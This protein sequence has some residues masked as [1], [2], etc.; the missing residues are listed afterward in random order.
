VQLE[1]QQVPSMQSPD[2][3]VA[4]VT[5]A[6]PRGAS[7]VHTLPTHVEPGAQAALVVHD[8]GHAAEPVHV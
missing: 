5:Q 4:A 2:A 6:V 1:L 8:V 3:H 7:G